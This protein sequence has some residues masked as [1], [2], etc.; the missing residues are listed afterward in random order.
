MRQHEFLTSQLD[1]GVSS[2]A[3]LLLFRFDI[4]PYFDGQIISWMFPKIHIG[5]LSKLELF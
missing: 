1:R 5:N 2:L 3:V 4:S